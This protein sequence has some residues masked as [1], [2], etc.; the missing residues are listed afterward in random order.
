MSLESL[1]PDSA[2]IDER[3]AWQHIDKFTDEIKN[4]THKFPLV[5][6]TGS[7]TV[8]EIPSTDVDEFLDKIRKLE[9]VDCAYKFPTGYKLGMG[10]PKKIAADNYYISGLVKQHYIG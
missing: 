8:Y 6:D 10:D 1:M 5:L 3:L 4:I 2:R 7:F 9:F